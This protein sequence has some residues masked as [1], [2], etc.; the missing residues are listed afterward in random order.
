[1]FRCFS[2]LRL[3]IVLPSFILLAIIEIV[4]YLLDC[5]LVREA[6]THRNNNEGS[7]G[8]DFF[9]SFLSIFS[10]RCSNFA[11]F[12]VYVLIC[13]LLFAFKLM[14]AN[15]FM[16][17]YRRGILPRRHSFYMQWREAE[18]AIYKMASFPLSKSVKHE[19]SIEY[20]RKLYSIN[21]LIYN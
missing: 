12:E 20:S 1:M 8:E 6:I 4:K 3:G 2:F 15:F 21:L 18:T 10:F 13:S 14:E 17:R 16:A 5:E 19:L 7:I 11:A 9:F